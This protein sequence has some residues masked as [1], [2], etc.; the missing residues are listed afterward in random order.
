MDLVADQYGQ[1]NRDVNARIKQALD[2][3]H[4]LA[5]GKQGGNRTGRA[6]TGDFAGKLLFETLARH[7]LSEGVYAA[8]GDDGVAGG[9]RH[10]VADCRISGR[11]QDEGR[12]LDRARGALQQD[13]DI[14]VGKIAH[15]A[16]ETR[17]LHGLARRC[18]Q[19]LRHITDPAAD[20]AGRR[21]FMIRSECRHPAGDFREEVSSFEFEIVFVEIGHGTGT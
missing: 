14:P 7:G 9:Q 17:I 15:M 12:G 19:R 5:P 16:A 18:R 4:I 21:F 2:P 10:G 11:A 8:R 13:L 6:F 1:T 20:Q 3:N